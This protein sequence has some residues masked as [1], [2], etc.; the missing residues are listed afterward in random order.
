MKVFLDTSVLTAY[1]CP[2]PRSKRVQRELS[3][4]VLPSL[5]PLVEIEFY[6]VVARKVRSGGMDASA[7]RRVFAE[8]RRHLAES[9]F[10]V[11]PVQAG[12]YALARQ[13]LEELDSPLR[14]VDALHLASALN[15]GLALLTA[16][17]TLAE[18]AARFGVKR[19][20]LP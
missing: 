7:A 6:C 20:L 8:F 4:A 18:A 11:V 3:R 1:Y 2:E 15:N 14:S 19:R 17:K 12:E 13:W 5:S 10:H 9:R 16:D